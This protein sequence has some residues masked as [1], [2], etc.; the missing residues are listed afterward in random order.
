MRSLALSATTTLAVHHRC[1]TAT[2]FG[3]A[4]RKCPPGPNRMVK[5]KIG[6]PESASA[7]NPAYR[8]ATESPAKAGL[9]H[10]DDS[11]RNGR[12][13]LPPRGS[14]S[15]W[16]RPEPLRARPSRDRPSD[17]E[18]VGLPHELVVGR[19]PK[20]AGRHC[21]LLRI[22]RGRRHRA[23]SEP[24]ARSGHA[25]PCRIRFRRAGVPKG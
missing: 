13:P 3:G 6:D 1:I 19:L 21:F 24:D 11:A 17:R 18:A 2:A 4:S 14:S 16:V 25:L 12:A 7:K 9:S 8:P 5:P 22:R 23:H 20:N 15:S 10:S